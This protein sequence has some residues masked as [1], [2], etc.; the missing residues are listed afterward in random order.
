MKFAP[1]LLLS[2]LAIVAVFA[3]GTLMVARLVRERR[4]PQSVLAWLLGSALVPYLGIPAYFIFGARRRRR[5]ARARASESRPRL[6]PSEVAREGVERGLV[7]QGVP[8]ASV[9]NRFELYTTGDAMYAA[10]VD[11]IEKAQQTLQLTL[12]IIH[13]DAVGRDILERLA[14]RAAEGVRIQLLMDGLGSFTTLG[15]HYRK[16]VAAGG[17]VAVFH[18]LWNPG[19]WAEAN[20]RNHRK[21][22]V[23]DG[24]V[25]L[26]GGLNVA[27]EYIGPEPGGK[28]WEELA[29]VVEG[30]AARDFARL[31]GDDWAYA[32]ETEPLGLPEKAAACTP[33]NARVQIVH[34][35]PDVENDPLYG[36]LL[37]ALYSS[38]QRVWIATPYFIPDRALNLAIANA[39]HRGIDVRLLL[40]DR[41]NHRIADWARGP[42]LR[43]LHEAGV[44]IHR[45]TSGMMHAK[46]LIVDDELAMVGSANFDLRSLYLAYE[47]MTAL[48][49]PAEIRSLVDWYEDLSRGTAD[50]LAP[51]SFLRELGEGLARLVAPLL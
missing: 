47:V 7:A 5:L 42:Y 43:E 23:A 38:K 18:P 31:A 13:P 50:G 35:E 14:R 10:I 20:L 44:R 21:I 27:H 24:R 17:E 6:Q 45:Y 16:L 28:Y 9:G 22:I 12:F 37:Q 11:L 40:P 36:A 19:R 48:Y 3:A 8:P 25:A 32:S 39:S 51:P 26:S 15:F 30:P 34:S 33:G 41:S 29:F 4:S 2:H 1:D 49:D 46:A